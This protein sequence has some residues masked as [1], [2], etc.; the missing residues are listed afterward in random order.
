MEASASVIMAVAYRLITTVILR[1]LFGSDGK[2]SG[3]NGGDLGLIPGSGISSG[4]GNGY[5]LQYFC[6]ENSMDRGAQWSIVH[7]ATESDMTEQLT[8][9]S[10]L[11][12]I[13]ILYIGSV[14]F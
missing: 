12:Q 6:L 14:T 2:E 8:L 7:V 11:W 5:L 3:C 4:E 1:R 10:S 13:I 9:L